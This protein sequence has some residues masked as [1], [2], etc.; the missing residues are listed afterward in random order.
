M[1]CPLFS[2]P[3]STYSTYSTY[4]ETMTAIEGDSVTVAAV[5]FEMGQARIFEQ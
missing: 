2:T 3:S 4:N 1:P 5:M